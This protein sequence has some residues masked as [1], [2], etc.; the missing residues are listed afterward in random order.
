MS[1]KIINGIKADIQNSLSSVKGFKFQPKK[2]LLPFVPYILIS[3]VAN[4]VALAYRLSSGTTL[5]KAMNSIN[6]LN[7]LLEM[8]YIS[9]NLK[10]LFYGLCGG[11]AVYL[12]VYF[13]K[14]NAKKYRQGVEYGSARFGNAK[15]IAPFID[16]VFENN[17]IL[18]QTERIML[19]RNKIP[20]YNINKNVLVIG[21]SGSGK[22]RFH[23]KPNIMQM[24]AN[25]CITDPKGTVLLEV[26]KMLV[27]NGYK[28]K[29]LNT[30]NF[31]DSMQYNP[32]KYIRSENDILK[33]VTCIMENTKGEDSKGGE[34]FWAKAEA[35]Y[36]QAI[37]AYIYYEAPENEKN[38]TTL[39]EFLNASEVREDD[40]N[41]KNAV[42]MMFDKLEAKNPNHF[43]VKQYLKFRLAAGKTLKSILI[44]CGARLAP[45]DIAEVRKLMEDDTIEI[46]KLGDKEKSALFVIVSD[47]DKT[48]NFI[49]AMMYSQMFN[50]LC[51][52]ALENG[53]ALQRHVTFLLDEFA[54]QKIPNFEQLISVI[55]SRE[56]SAHIIVQ[57]QSQLKAIYK[58]HAETI[59]G[60][61][62]T[63]LFLGG[64]EKSTLK[65]ISE[66][67]GKET[68]DTY[69]TSDTRGQSRS[70]GLNYQKLGKALMSEDELAVMD[71]GK[72]ILQVQG[73][74]PF[75]SDKFD[76][77]KHKQYKHLLDY[78]DKNAFDIKDYMKCRL[79]LNYEDSYTVYEM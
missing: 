65:E 59:I 34:D 16:P 41:F 5:E 40:E 39:L 68:I 74:R 18:T 8:P 33:L 4:K 58:D 47:T 20:K 38:M 17:K 11:V 66:M 3:I 42:D 67:M 49:A 44:S 14:K 46:D 56:I 75:F 63:I 43:A 27:D 10:D 60:N 55:R 1:N 57:T 28:I 79:K 30:I 62:S 64:K 71:N 78:S 54:N 15:D 51:D 69:N 36:Y 77:T 48:F 50:V 13:K 31:S 21:G 23:V 73:V 35:L 76:I 2:H 7:T 45:F 25:L 26:G 32:F 61:C 70:Y 6:G 22:T 19:G 72:C 37:I 29:V 12:I 53:G 9:L 24:N 52:K